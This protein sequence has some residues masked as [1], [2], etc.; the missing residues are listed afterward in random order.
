MSGLP[1]A[2]CRAYIRHFRGWEELDRLGR[3]MI[4]HATRATFHGTGRRHEERQVELISTGFP[5]ELYYP[6]GLT[7]ND[8]VGALCWA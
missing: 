1:R 3:G 2:H 6:E 7:S 4:S 5:L 8:C